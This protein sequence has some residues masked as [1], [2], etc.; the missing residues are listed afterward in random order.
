MGAHPSAPFM[1][2]ERVIW[3]NNA[4]L[5]VDTGFTF[6][7]YNSDKTQVYFAGSAATL[8]AKARAAQDV[9]MEIDAAIVEKL[10]PGAIPAEL[11]DYSVSLAEK[12]GIAEGYMGLDGN[13]V[14]F[15]GHGIGLAIDEWPVLAPRFE[16]PLEAGMTIALEPKIGIRGFGMVGTENTSEVTDHGGVCLNGPSRDI[17]FIG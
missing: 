16:S 7:G 12:A 5:G 17:V 3:E 15:V 10:R 8:P 6:E 4:P 1:G 9:C 13:R 2:N 14:P 11:Y